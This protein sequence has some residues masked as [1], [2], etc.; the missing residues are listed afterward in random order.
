MMNVPSVFD[1]EGIK[2]E[3]VWHLMEIEKDLHKKGTLPT[4]YVG[5]P[6]PT[7]KVLWRQRNMIVQRGV[8]PCSVYVSC[9]RRTRNTTRPRQNMVVHWVYPSFTQERVSD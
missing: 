4:E 6:L 1:R 7:I 3:I 5:A 2:S 8:H 9:M